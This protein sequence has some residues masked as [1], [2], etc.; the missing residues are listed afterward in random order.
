RMVFQFGPR[1]AV[2]LEP[3]TTVALERLDSQEVRLRVDGNVSVDLTKRAPDERFVIIAG[4]RRVEVRGTAFTVQSKGDALNVAVARGRVAVS[5]DATSV[6]VAAGGVLRVP[7]GGTL[8][9]LTA[10]ALSEVDLADLVESVAMPWA[11]SPEAI[12]AGGLAR[13]E[14]AAKSE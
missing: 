7:E 5:D 1:S 2:A 10:G 11:P 3:G 9:S 8:G 4:R 12:H 14:V 6:E 13:I